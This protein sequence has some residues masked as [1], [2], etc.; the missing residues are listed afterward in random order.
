MGLIQRPIKTGGNRTYADEIAG[1][2]K[3]AKGA[4]VDADLDTIITLV[5]GNL[6]VNNLSNDAV[7][8]AKIKDAA[9]TP[10]KLNLSGALQSDLFD[11]SLSYLGSDGEQDACTLP[12]ITLGDADSRVLLTGGGGWY[13]TFSLSIVNTYTTFYAR[14]YR[15]AVLIKYFV[16]TYMDQSAGSGLYVSVPI[17]VPSYV[18]TPGSAGPHTYKITGE[19]V[20]ASPAG[21]Q[22]KTLS[23]AAHNGIITA[24][25]LVR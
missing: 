19:A 13:L 14:Y 12:A 25:E 18:D 24:V 16:Y 11:A 9:V 6:D 10:A 23:T 4:E 3:Y 2:N 21:I 7:E 8:E 1:G 15:G 22:W 17:P 5:N 20:N